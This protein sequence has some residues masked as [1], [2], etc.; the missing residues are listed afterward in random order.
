MVKKTIAIIDRGGRGAA[1]AYAYSKSKHVAKIVVIPGSGLIQINCKKP[2]LTFPDIEITD[3][4]QIVSI[5]KKERVDLVDVAQDD[6]VATGVSDALL[7]A[8]FLVTGPTKKAGRIEWSKAYS[9]RLLKKAGVLQPEF[10]VLRSLKDGTKYLDEQ[11]DQ[12]WFVKADGLVRGKGALSADNN[13]DAKERIKELS[14]F[15]KPGRTYLLE[16]WLKDN[17]KTAEEFSAF[18]V[19]DGKS[20]QIIGYAQDHKRIFD[21]DKG[22][23]TGGI[24][25]SAPP[26][27]VDRDIKDQSQVIFSKVF[28]ELS[29]RKTPYRG[30]LYLGG[31]IVGGK[32]YVVEF[33]ARWG[34]PEAEALIPAIKND[35][36]ELSHSIARQKLSSLK[37]HTDKKSRV[38]VTGCAKGYPNDIKKVLG[39]EIK[40]L[41]KVSKL[42]DI[43]IFGA[44]ITENEGKHFVEGG[45][46]FHVMG[47]G[48]DVV[49]ARAKVY[50]AMRLIKI[51]DNGLYFRTDIGWRDVQRRKG[52][53]IK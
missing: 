48:K 5:C 1:L 3:K 43:L 10:K 40:G 30:V 19:S 37:V 39:A 47:V 52:R 41:T 46:L 6:A 44:S 35:M 28:E 34:D 31:I 36:Y 16:K 4:K 11:P 14:K 27:V 29:R 49:E 51:E 2:V 33:N 45:R 42:K 18:A 25:V 53:L 17:S 8:R 12:P 24:G 7:H 23:N 15:G 26:I 50:K 38:V 20:F 21:G 9:R 13:K 32:V 22:E